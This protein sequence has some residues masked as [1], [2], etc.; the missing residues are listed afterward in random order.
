MLVALLFVAAGDVAD[1]FRIGFDHRDR[2]A[3]VVGHVGHQVA[4]QAVRLGQGFRR[5]V[6]RAGQV[7][8][9]A[10]GTALEFDV[11]VAFRQFGRLLRDVPDRARDAAGDVQRQ[12]AC[13][14]QGDRGHRHELLRQDADRGTHRG[15]RSEREEAHVRPEFA[16]DLRRVHLRDRLT[17]LVGDLERHGLAV[18]GFQ[19]LSREVDAAAAVVVTAGGTLVRGGDAERFVFRLDVEVHVVGA[20][21]IAHLLQISL[22]VQFFADGVLQAEGTHGRLDLLLHLSLVVLLQEHGLEQPQHA[23]QSQSEHDKIRSEPKAHTACS[24]FREFLS[25]F[26]LQTC[27]QCLSPS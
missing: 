1:H 7:V 5:R 22:Q 13:H 10:V 18:V 21:D 26:S 3:Q 20:R 25:V 11:V 16:V 4:L 2:R 27:S 8:D 24:V 9:L 6:Q 19:A 12:D 23:H 17:G 14:D 15:Q